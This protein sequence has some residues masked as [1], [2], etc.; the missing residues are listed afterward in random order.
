M[1]SEQNIFW[2]TF[3]ALSEVLLM[4]RAFGDIWFV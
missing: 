1:E 2:L 3:F 4:Q